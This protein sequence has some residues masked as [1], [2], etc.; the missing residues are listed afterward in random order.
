[1]E[2]QNADGYYACGWFLSRLLGAFTFS[3]L[4][5][6]QADSSSPRMRAGDPLSFHRFVEALTKRSI[7]LV[8]MPAALT[9]RSVR[10]L[11]VV[12]ELDG[13]MPM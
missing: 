4:A 12:G 3:K 5:P 1:M 9:F 10:Q 11:P 2:L 13:M 8:M 7:R 6:P